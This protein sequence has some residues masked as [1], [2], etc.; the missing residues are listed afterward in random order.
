ML[1]RKLLNECF[2]HSIVYRFNPAPT[3]VALIQGGG[4]Q[5]ARLIPY[6]YNVNDIAED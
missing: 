4:A 1:I 2:N 6:Q 3:L 5:S